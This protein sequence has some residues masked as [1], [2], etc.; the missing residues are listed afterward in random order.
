[1][2]LWN[3]HKGD[4]LMKIAILG[5]GHIG[6]TLV[7]RLSAAGHDVKVAN[8]RGPETIEAELL[9]SG[10]RA[11]TAQE[12]LTD[13]DAVIL[14]IPLNRIPDVA[15]LVA[16][17]PDETVVIDTSNY[18]PFRDDRIE[19]IEAGQ[20][21][22]VWVAERLGRPIAKAWNAIGSASLAHKAQSAGMPGRIAIPVAADRDRDREVA[23]ALVEDT[24]LDAFDAGT[25]ADSWRQQPG[26]PAYCTDLT[27][28]EMGAALA[29][30]DRA[31]LPKRRDLGVAV[32][33]ERLGAGTN[34]DE[35]WGVRLVRVINM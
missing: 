2:T 13:V 14:S 15:P 30:A 17:L 4:L 16:K 28:E 18:Y 12:A 25:L 6:K 35:D 10:A 32:M 21:E 5:T 29:A 26:A 27:R 19:P 31:R 22:S 23:M 7:R 20:V 9:S 11:V 24:G 33:Q 1:M 34:P 8:S 3:T